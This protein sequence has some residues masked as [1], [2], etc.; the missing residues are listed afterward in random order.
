MFIPI[1]PALGLTEQIYEFLRRQI[2]S[3]ELAPGSRLPSTRGLAEQVGVSR[4]TVLGAFDWLASEG[5]VE[6]RGQRGT[7]V[8]AVT[9][10]PPP[11][12]P[13]GEAK[14]IPLRSRKN[15]LSSYGKRL[16]SHRT[17]YSPYS[18][19]D[20][21]LPYDF[22]HNVLVGDRQSDRAWSTIFRQVLVDRSDAGYQDPEVARLREQLLEHIAQARGVRC[23]PEQLVL[24]IGS[25]AAFHIIAQITIEPGDLVALEEAHYLGIRS[26]MRAHGAK[27]KGIPIDEHGIRPER[28]ESDA[29][30]AKLLYLAP[31]HQWPTGAMLPYGRRRAVLEWARRQNAYVIEN[32]HNVEYRHGGKPV[33]SLQSLDEDDRVFYVGNLLRLR[34]R[35]LRVGFVV[36]PLHLVETFRAAL[37]LAGAH[38]SPEEQLAFARFIEEGHL[39]RTNRRVRQVAKLRR[40]TLS[41]ALRESLGDGVNLIVPRTG[42]HIHAT[43]PN[44]PSSAT[45]ELLKR[46]ARK[47]VRVY[48]DLPFYLEP[49]DQLGLIFGFGDLDPPDIDEGIRRFASVF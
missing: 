22:R 47:G 49:R 42:F 8:S 21:I 29:P 37:S 12:R 40:N 26:T 44:V 31:S 43:L 9:T 1:D 46:A 17:I 36:V 10:S 15:R 4:N 25:Q 16:K 20:D 48:P 41:R 13:R 33:E 11:R 5:Y 6:G 38:S 30:N 35:G 28:L 32:D 23:R 39:D 14:S 27:L 19:P 3:G 2:E 7:V 45:D 34:T 18:W 24:L